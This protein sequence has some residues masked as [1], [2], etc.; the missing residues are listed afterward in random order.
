MNEGDVAYLAFFTSADTSL[1]PQELQR[2]GIQIRLLKTYS[3][4]DLYEAL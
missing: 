4:G 1:T 3:D 2:A